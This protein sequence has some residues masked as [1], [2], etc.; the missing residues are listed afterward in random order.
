MQKLEGI[1]GGNAFDWGRASP[2]YAKYRDIYPEEF[3]RRMIEAGLCVKGQK[4]LDIGTGTGV[5]PRNLYKYGAKFTG[6]DISENQISEARRLS[7]EQGMDIEYIV[8]SAEDVD[9]PVESFDVVTAC[10][11]FMYFDKAI[12]LPKIHKMLKAE[13]RFCIVYMYHLPYEDEIARAS[14]ELVLKYNPSWTGAGWR[15]EELTEPDWA[16]LLFAMD[17]AQAFDV[18]LPFTR[19]SW[20]GRIKACRGIGA[21]SLPPKTIAAFEK[22]HAAML[23]RIPESFEIL[24]FVTIQ[25]FVKNTPPGGKANSGEVK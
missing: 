25:S 12:A 23:S 24:H 13:G 5:L 10:Q 14:E 18:M 2:D 21:S 9:F 20:H 19:E 8:S 17:K 11:C 6:A 22:E 15:R 16:P 1:D 4:I 7:G 3:Y